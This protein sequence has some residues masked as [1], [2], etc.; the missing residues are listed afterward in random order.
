MHCDGNCLESRLRKARS[1]EKPTPRRDVRP[2]VAGVQTATSPFLFHYV[3]G[4]AVSSY[5]FSHAARAT[6]RRQAELGGS[7]WADLRAR[8]SSEFQCASD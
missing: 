6:E 1:P 7:I 5:L 4:R 8:T 3:K 2:A